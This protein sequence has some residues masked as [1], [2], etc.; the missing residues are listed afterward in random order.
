MNGIHFINKGQVRNT[1]YLWLDFNDRDEIKWRI[2]NRF[3]LCT[4][5][6]VLLTNFGRY[7]NI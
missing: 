7:V 4:F 3:W 6:F 5:V 2:G 1:F